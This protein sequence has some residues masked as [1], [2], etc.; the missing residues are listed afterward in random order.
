MGAHVEAQV[1]VRQEAGATD[2]AQEGAHQR[3]GR[4]V[5]VPAGRRRGGHLQA[6]HPSNRCPLAPVGAAL[7]LT[8]APCTCG[9][10]CPGAGGRA[11]PAGGAS[12]QARCGRTGL[13]SQNQTGSQPL[14]QGCCCLQGWSPWRRCQLPRGSAG[15]PGRHLARGQPALLRHLPG[16]HF[17]N[18]SA[19]RSQGTDNAVAHCPAAA[20]PWASE[21][22]GI[23]GER[24][25]E[26]L[27]A[28]Q[29][30]ADSR[31]L[32]VQ[33]LSR[34]GGAAV[35]SGTSALTRLGQKSKRTARSSWRKVNM[36]LGSKSFPPVISWPC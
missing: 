25:S 26:G 13:C 34:K 35:P 10:S 31:L 24:E 4:P 7:P 8:F 17:S 15:P 27:A 30:P 16:E 9:T 1:L 14:P 36:L 20:E 6:A 22:A 5:A 12:C 18:G 28:G 2:P 3:L 29:N 32:D 33:I 21:A 19:G 23:N 11:G